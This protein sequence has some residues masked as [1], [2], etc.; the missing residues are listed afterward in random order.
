VEAA[1]LPTPRL[2]NEH[3][4]SLDE[5]LGIRWKRAA[6]LDPAHIDRVVIRV[7]PEISNQATLH[8]A[9]E[10]AYDRRVRA[11]LA[12][13]LACGGSSPGPGIDATPGFTLTSPDLADG[14]AF[15]AANTCDGADTSPALAWT[16][17]A[18]PGYAVVLTDQSI[19]LVHWIIDDIAGTSLPAGVDKSAQPGNV[20][21]AHQ[22][23]SF[24]GTTFGYR[25]PCPPAKHTYQFVVYALDTAAVGPV[26]RT[27]G[28]A[29]IQQHATAQ[30]GLT[31]TYERP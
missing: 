20:P 26:D 17:V 30:T 13:A 2:G 10:P 29:T 24:D 7:R 25:G 9:R 21:G 28:V 8:A 3:A 4:Q 12:I 5:G 31:G 6:T 18:A 1:R 19:D 11:L 23:A 22:A 14:A 15:A 16:G 27:T